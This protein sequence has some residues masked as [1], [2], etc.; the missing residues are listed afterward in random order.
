MI[1]III[2]LG[3]PPHTTPSTKTSN[4]SLVSPQVIQQPSLVHN[5]SI[6]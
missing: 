5:I 6:D 3:L 4:H 2:K 1:V